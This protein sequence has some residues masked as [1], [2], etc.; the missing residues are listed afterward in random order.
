VRSVVVT[1][2]PLHF[3]PTLLKISYVERQDAPPRCPTLLTKGPRVVDVWA[4]A[5]FDTLAVG[6]DGVRKMCLFITRYETYQDGNLDLELP[7]GADRA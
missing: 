4:S 1:T 7:E 5:A 3:L 2:T 6:V